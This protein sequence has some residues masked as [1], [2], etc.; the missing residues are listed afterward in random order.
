MI[1]PISCSGCL[2]MHLARIFFLVVDVELQGRIPT[3][4]YQDPEVQ[5]EAK[6][7][8]QGGYLGPVVMLLDTNI[9]LSMSRFLLLAQ[10]FCQI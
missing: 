5:G 7:L 10:Y 1:L 8:A 3:C 2:S 4:L 9:Q 6:A